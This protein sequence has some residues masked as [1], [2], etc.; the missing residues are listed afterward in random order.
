MKFIDVFRVPES[1][2]DLWGHIVQLQFFNN[3]IWRQKASR[4][5]LSRLSK[6]S[7]NIR[8]VGEWKQSLKIRKA[9]VSVPH[10]GCTLRRG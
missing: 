5:K 4:K 2:R 6:H 3:R 10:M 8:H 7:R 1:G 9:E